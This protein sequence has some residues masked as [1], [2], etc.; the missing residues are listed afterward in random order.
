MPAQAGGT[1]SFAVSVSHRDRFFIVSLASGSFGDTLGRFLGLLG[2]SL[3]VRM[4]RAAL[5]E[6]YGFDRTGASTCQKSYFRVFSASGF[7][8]ASGSGLIT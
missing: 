4:G 8:E 5:F 3:S 7:S 6:I 2:F 1:G